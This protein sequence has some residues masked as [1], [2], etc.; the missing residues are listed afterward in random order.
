[1]A[2]VKEIG[3]HLVK[4]RKAIALDNINYNKIREIQELLQEEL[5]IKLSINQTI[6]LILKLYV[7]N[8]RN[9]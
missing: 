9:K 1:M 5:G 3:T 8:N 2:N 4:Y 7:S 6:T